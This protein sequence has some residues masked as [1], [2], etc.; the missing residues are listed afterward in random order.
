MSKTNPTKH[1][2]DSLINFGMSETLSLLD[3]LGLLRYG[4]HE[5]FSLLNF[6]DISGERAISYIIT[7][8]IGRHLG[9]WRKLLKVLQ[10]HEYDYKNNARF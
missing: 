4:E 5:T 3:I 1:H 10:F 7:N 8:A 2:R 6:R 9:K